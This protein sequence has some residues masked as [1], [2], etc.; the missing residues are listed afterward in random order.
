MWDAG[1]RGLVGS[2]EWVRVKETSGG[3]RVVFRMFCGR[4]RPEGVTEVGSFGLRSCWVGPW[5]FPP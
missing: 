4:S 1:G 2:G 5:L 3:W